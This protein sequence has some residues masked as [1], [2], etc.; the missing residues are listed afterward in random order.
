MNSMQTKNKVLK[1]LHVRYL[2]TR[3]KYILTNY[4][5]VTGLWSLSHYSVVSSL[6]PDPVRAGRY[7]TDTDRQAVMFPVP[8][9]SSWPAITADRRVSAG[10]PISGGPSPFGV[11]P[12][13]VSA[14]V[15]VDV[16][17]DVSVT[18]LQELPRSRRVGRP[19]VS[20]PVVARPGRVRRRRA[21]SV[22]RLAKSAGKSPVRRSQANT[23]GSGAR[24]TD[25]G[26]RTGGAVDR[27]GRPVDRRLCCWRLA[28]ARGGR[29]TGA[30]P[31]PP[32]TRPRRTR[33]K[34]FTEWS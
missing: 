31:A 23:V 7:L 11:S 18:E 1:L 24:T 9:L 8:T 33:R 26:P 5:Q 32:N 6:L 21:G 20:A 3:S 15:S 14:T 19:R 29:V 30:G 12:F 2:I 28:T 10:R 13:S 27:A 22:D 16:S 17:A 4:R 34:K 25:R